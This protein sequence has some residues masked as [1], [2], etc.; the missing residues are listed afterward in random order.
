MRLLNKYT[1]SLAVGATEI[2]PGQT[3]EVDGSNLAVL[4]WITAGM[5]EDVTPA[6][7]QPAPKSDK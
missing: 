4:A 3:G 2:E 5:A 7:A 6:K 1:A